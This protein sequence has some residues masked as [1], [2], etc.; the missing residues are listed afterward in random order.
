MLGVTGHATV[1]RVGPLPS[2]V[3]TRIMVVPR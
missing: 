3:G 1:A 2:G